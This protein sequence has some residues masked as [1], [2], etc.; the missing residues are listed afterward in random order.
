MKFLIN[1]WITKN[2]VT[3]VSLLHSYVTIIE[4][5]DICILTFYKGEDTCELVFDNM[6]EARNF[7]ID[8]INES[9]DID[10]IQRE[11]EEYYNQKKLVL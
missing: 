11:Y 9:E 4:V 7:T 10:T 8:V 5:K 1:P 6:D 2:G 3:T